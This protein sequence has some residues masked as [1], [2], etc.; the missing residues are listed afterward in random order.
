MFYSALGMLNLVC[1]FNL[2]LIKSE[3]QV[4]TARL[5][6]PLNTSDSANR[7]TSLLGIKGPPLLFEFIAPISRLRRPGKQGKQSQ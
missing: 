3:V 7:R 6:L 4:L 2:P 5:G 1:V